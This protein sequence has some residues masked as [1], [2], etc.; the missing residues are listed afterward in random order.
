MTNRTA[1]C[2]V[3]AVSDLTAAAAAAL[4]NSSSSLTT[5]SQLR[6]KLIGAVAADAAAAAVV[7]FDDRRANAFLRSS[8]L[9]RHVARDQSLI[10]A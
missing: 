8:A 6:H 9:P 1:R 4:L 5:T 3:P 10:D 7:Q 2:S